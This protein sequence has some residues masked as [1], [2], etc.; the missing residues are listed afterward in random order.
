MSRFGS[1]PPFA[2]GAAPGAVAAFFN[3]VYSWMAAGLALTAVVAWWTSTRPDI[4]H[5]VYH[6]GVLIVLFVVEILLV[7]V[8]SAATQ[9]LSATTA[10]A[11]FLV[12][13]ALNGL[14]LSGIFMVYASA[15]IASAFI[16]SAAMFGVMGLYGM[17]TKSDLS[18]W[19]PI[20]FMA[21]I[22]LIVASVVDI[23][24]ASTALTWIVSYGG[25]AIFA[26]LTAYDTQQLRTLA[27]MTSSDE[28]AASR[29]AVN[30]AL[31]LYLD[32]LNLFLLMLR[33]LGGRR[34]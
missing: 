12:Y 2:Q 34:R 9:R 19:G 13:A 25:V 16:A 8:I 32:F 1:T 18:G 10:T 17:L 22:G 11:L 24:M 21:L 4:M 31:R 26:G 27:I 6:S 15:T 7:G 28:A 23:F 14:T 29:Y 20:L 33:I 3:A 30:G 5:Q